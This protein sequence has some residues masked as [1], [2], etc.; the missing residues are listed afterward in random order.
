MR[1][2]T[3]I[4]A[5]AFTLA[6]C[7]DDDPVSSGVSTVT[8]TGLTGSTISVGES[9]QLSAVVHDGDGNV[10]PGA[11]IT[12]TSEAPVVLAIGQTGRIL[13]LAAGNASIIARAGSIA[14]APLLLTVQA[15]PTVGAVVQA[16]AS[17][18]FT[19]S[20]ATIARGR[21][22]VYGFLSTVEHNVTFDNVSGAPTN[23]PATRNDVASRTFGTA[24]TFPYRCTIHPG[25]NGQIVVNP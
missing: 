7:G 11:T 19:P 6:A 16:T 24:G 5:A 3:M 8:I 12:W 25:M 15:S 23:V 21:S 20:N 14:S 13:G 1:T 10:V 18:Q 2:V 4:L 22:V 17:N 9:V